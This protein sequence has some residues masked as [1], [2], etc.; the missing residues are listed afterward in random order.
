[1]IAGEHFQYLGYVPSVRSQT[2]LKSPDE[3]VK[4]VSKGAAKAR[5]LYG[6]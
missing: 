2:G 4:G 1:M 5:G 6:I 3:P